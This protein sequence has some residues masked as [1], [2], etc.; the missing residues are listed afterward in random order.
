MRSTLRIVLRLCAVL[1]T[2]VALSGGAVPASAKCSNDHKCTESSLE[3][4]EDW[5]WENSQTE[6]FHCHLN[7][8][9]CS[10]GEG[11]CEPPV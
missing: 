10:Q 9:V 1:V 5:C 4:G 6:G 11:S 7:H 8:G 2:Y 3:N